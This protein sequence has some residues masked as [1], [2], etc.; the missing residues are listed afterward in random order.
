MSDLI[1]R[2]AAIDAIKKYNRGSV[3]PEDWHRGLK[4]GIN[5]IKE[6]PSAEAETKCIA[7]IKVDVDEIVERIKEEYDIVDG[8]I[9]CSE[10]LPD[11]E[12]WVLV[13]VENECFHEG[14]PF[15]D[16]DVRIHKNTFNTFNTWNDSVTAWMPLPKP[17]EGDADDK[18]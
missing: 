9:P 5:I 7:Q 10:R 14:N 6:V 12:R 11:E 18:E 16:M 1:S 2:Q 4:R 17:W 13:T 15:I 3:M 8:W